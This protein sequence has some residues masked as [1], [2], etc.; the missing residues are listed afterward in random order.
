MLGVVEVFLLLTEIMLLV[1][2]RVWNHWFWIGDIFTQYLER[3]LRCVDRGPGVHAGAVLRASS[4]ELC[5]M[6]D[7]RI[8]FDS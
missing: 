2:V 4:H 7:V 1:H 8:V 5:D 6:L 3:F